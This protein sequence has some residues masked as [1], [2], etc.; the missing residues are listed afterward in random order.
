MSVRPFIS[1]WSILSPGQGSLISLLLLLVAEVSLK[2]GQCCAGNRYCVFYNFG[3]FFVCFL[4][5]HYAWCDREIWIYVIVV[6][7]RE[8]WIVITVLCGKETQIFIL[9]LCDRKTCIFIIVLCGVETWIFIILCDRE[10]G[11]LLLFCVIGK[12][13]YLLLFCVAWKH[14]YLLFCVTGKLDIYYCFVW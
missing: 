2:G 9:V 1:G 8:T 7:D 12:H 3:G 10:I 6:C 11:Y 5:F 14:E 4:P 13:G